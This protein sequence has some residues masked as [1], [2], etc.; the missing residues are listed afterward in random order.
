MNPLHKIEYWRVRRQQRSN[1]EHKHDFLASGT[2]KMWR[3]EDLR[4]SIARGDEIPTKRTLERRISKIPWLKSSHQANDQLDESNRAAN[5][6][7]LDA[8]VSGARKKPQSCT[9]T[10]LSH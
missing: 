5:Q 1:T 6:F 10:W 7:V 8:F 3:L 9:K 2:D 4:L